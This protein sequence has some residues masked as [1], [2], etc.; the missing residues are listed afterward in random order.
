MSLRRRAESIIRNYFD[1]VVGMNSMRRTANMLRRSGDI[2]SAEFDA[3][4][5]ILGFDN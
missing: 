5:E 4:A 2:N 3:I 1:G